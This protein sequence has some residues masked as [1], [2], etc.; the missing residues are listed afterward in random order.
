MK[1][2]IMERNAKIVLIASAAI[3][4]VSGTVFAIASKKL[5]GRMDEGLEAIVDV[6]SDATTVTQN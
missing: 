2:N 1:G 5:R 3:V 4:G 6:V